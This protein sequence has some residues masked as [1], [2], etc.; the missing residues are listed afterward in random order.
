MSKVKVTADEAGNVIIRSENNPTWGYIR[1]EQKR[2]IVDQNGFAS[3]TTL[4]A[5]VPGE[6]E[7]LNGFGWT[8]GASVEGKV[9]V[10][11]STT[12]FNAKDPERDYKIAGDSGVVCMFGED[13]IYRKN[14]FTF[15][16]DACD[17]TIEHTNGDEIKEAYAAA[18]SNAIQPNEDFNM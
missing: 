4:S 17:H 11:E 2:N 12:P 5:L 13:P 10:K 1:V 3:S 7:T 14:I 6:V 18:K 8:A 15:N 9:I 16:A